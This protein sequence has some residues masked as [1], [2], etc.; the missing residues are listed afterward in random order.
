M[1]YRWCLENN[2]ESSDI[3]YKTKFV[4]GFDCKF[5]HELLN[6]MNETYK[7]VHP[8][9]KPRIFEIRSDLDFKDV[10]YDSNYYE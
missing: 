4:Q 1:Q 5:P 6:V 10:V 3:L 2:I 9:F 8:E 7:H